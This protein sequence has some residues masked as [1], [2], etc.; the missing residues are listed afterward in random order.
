MKPRHINFINLALAYSLS[1]SPALSYAAAVQQGGVQ[2][3]SAQRDD[4]LPLFVRYGI[5]FRR[6]TGSQTASQDSA[7]PAKT[8]EVRYAAMLQREAVLNDNEMRSLLEIAKECQRQ[9]AELDARAKAIIQAARAQALNEPPPELAQLQQERNS[10]ILKAR[11]TLQTTL[12]EE[13][14][15]RL[16]NYVVSHGNGRIFTLPPAGRPPIPLQATVTVLS[17]D[18]QTAKRQFHPGEKIIIQFALL[19]NSSQVIRVKEADLY[20]WFELFRVEEPGRAPVFIFPPEKDSAIGAAQATE[21]VELVPGQQTIVGTF[22]LSR[23]QK[24]LKPG[25]YEVRAHP[26]VLLNRPPDKS[27]F[28]NLR[29]ADDPVTFE[30][31]P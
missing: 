10:T 18:G 29:S 9:V 31:V 13:A 23:I 5:L 15:Q 4:S 11:E 1:L 25:R 28:I 3:T 6:L 16:D 27:E 22:D 2:V 17:A 30:V 7:T 20:D 26:R 14:F 12:G 24:H 19:N 21:G 8:N